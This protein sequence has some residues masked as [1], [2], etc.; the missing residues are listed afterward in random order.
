V[1]DDRVRTREAFVAAAAGADLIITSGGVSVGEEDHV[2]PAVEAE[3]TLELWSIAMKPGK[4][5]AFGRVRDV[6]FIGLPGN[7]V[8]SFVT[9]LLFARPFVLCRQGVSASGT[10]AYAMRAG[11]DRPVP[12]SRREF[13]RVRRR[14]SDEVEAFPT[15]N[16]AVLNST[17]WADGLVD[18]P[19][20]ST[21]RR[22][23]A[24][25]YLAFA[26]LLS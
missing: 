24:V 15:Q 12:D 20:G 18:I 10:E 19:A 4:P 1:P 11:F 26:D 13:M 8:S 9:F 23:D 21:V 3:G 17:V 6:P 2:K 25:R 5:L 14:G 16:S 22:G 7:P